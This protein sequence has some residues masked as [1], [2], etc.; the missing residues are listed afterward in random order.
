[1]RLKSYSD[2]FRT[3]ESLFPDPVYSRFVDSHS[4]FER[5]A[6]FLRVDRISVK[7][8]IKVTFVKKKKKIQRDITDEEIRI[9]LVLP[10]CKSF[11]EKLVYKDS[12]FLSRH[13]IN[14][15]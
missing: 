2:M 15:L 3:E 13:V 4:Y 12:D 9:F 11:D 6:T 5:F 7:Y 10:L 8:L 14:I 1:M